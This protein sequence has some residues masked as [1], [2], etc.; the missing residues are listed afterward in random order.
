MP[1]KYEFTV[2]NPQRKLRYWRVYL[3]VA[4]Q[5]N[6]KFISYIDTLSSVIPKQEDGYVLTAPEHF[7]FAR[8]L[9]EIVKTGKVEKKADNLYKI[10]RK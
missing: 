9:D 6:E 10:V 2:S 7:G 5:D 3:T 1:W 4:E 8:F